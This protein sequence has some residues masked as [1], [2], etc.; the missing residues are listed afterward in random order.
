MT[1]A[2]AAPG[3]VAQRRRTRK[4]IVEATSQLLISGVDPTIVDIAKAA[5]V[6]RRTVYTYFPTLDQLLLDATVGAMSTDIDATL[7]AVTGADPRERVER[8]VD[9]ICRSI[10]EMM[11][12]GR[13]LIKLTV[14]ASPVDGAPKRG[15]RRVQW[16]ERAVEPLRNQLGPKRFENLVSSLAV[17]IGWEAFIVLTDVRGLSVTQARA[18]SRSAALALIDTAIQHAPE[19]AHDER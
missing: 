1:A 14:D 4:A 15:Y 18:I 17:V 8:M 3:R 12:L 11:P 13:K 6:S 16:I 9:A 7:D 5:D 19:G 2:D 10:G